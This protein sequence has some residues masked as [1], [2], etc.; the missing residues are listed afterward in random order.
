MHFFRSQC[1][2]QLLAIQKFLFQLLKRL[3][4]GDMSLGNFSVSSTIARGDQ[5]CHAATLKEGVVLD[6][7]V[8][9]LGKFAHLHQSDSDHRALGVVS[10]STKTQTC[11]NY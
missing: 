5:I 10:Q 11:I 2:L 6:A 8:K 9:S 1:A 4:R 3:S 7:N